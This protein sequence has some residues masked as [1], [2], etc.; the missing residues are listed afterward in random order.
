M[1]KQHQ[2]ENQASVI[3]QTELKIFHWDKTKWSLGIFLVSAN[4]KTALKKF[5][6]FILKIIHLWTYQSTLGLITCLGLSDHL[7][8]PRN[9][10]TQLKIF[11]FLSLI[12]VYLHGQK[13]K[14][15][16]LFS[17][18]MLIKKPKIWLTG[19]IWLHWFYDIF[20]TTKSIRLCG[21]QRKFLS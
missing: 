15:S 18:I 19:L 20:N 3:N 10:W 11:F 13:I 7:D 1:K 12:Y 14:I 2:K 16:L 17:D 21:G 9:I 6:S 8:M 5:A 4:K